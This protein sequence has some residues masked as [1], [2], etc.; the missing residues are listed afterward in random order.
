MTD[1][2]V[3]PSDK[4]PQVSIQL[5]DHSGSPEVPGLVETPKRRSAGVAIGVLAVLAGLLLWSANRTVDETAE[6]ERI[7]EV[8]PAIDSEAAAD[9]VRDP[10]EIDGPWEEFSDDQVERVPM[11][12]FIVSPVRGDDGW[13]ALRQVPG[14]S[15]LV[16][17]EDGLTWSAVESEFASTNL[18]GLD[19]VGE[20]WRTMVN[21]AALNEQRFS[22][23]TQESADTM[24]WE[25][26]PGA[27]LHTAAGNRPT[28]VDLQFGNSVVVGDQPLRLEEPVEEFASLLSTL[29]SPELAERACE[30]ELDRESGPSAFLILDCDGEVIGRVS[31]DDRQQMNTLSTVAFLLQFEAV[32]VVQLDGQAVERVVLP[33]G[34]QVASI[35][36]TVDGFVAVVIDTIGGVNGEELL[37]ESPPGKLIRW[38][39]AEGIVD[40]TGGLD[41][42]IELVDWFENGLGV[43]ADG[44]A[45]FASPSRVFRSSPPYVDWVPVL[46]APIDIDERPGTIAIGPDG[47][48]VVFQDELDQVWFGRTGGRWVRAPQLDDSRLVGV[49]LSSPTHIVGMFETEGFNFGL[50][51]VPIPAPARI[52][53]HNLQTIAPLGDDWLATTR[54]ASG[55][56]R[57]TND[58]RTWTVDAEAAGD[59]IEIYSLGESNGETIALVT[60]D[61]LSP[62]KVDGDI[63]EYDYLDTWGYGDDGWEPLADRSPIIVASGQV[64]HTLVG[65]ISLAVVEDRWQAPVP[66]VI[67]VLEQFV[68]ADVAAKTCALNRTVLADG[69]ADYELL[70]CAGAPVGLIAAADVEVASK[71]DDLLAFTQEVL[72]TRT[73]VYVSIPGRDLQIVELAPSQLIL[74]ITLTDAGF[75]AFILDSSQVL[76]NVDI[77][78]SQSFAALLIGW[79]AGDGPVTPF[80]TPIQTPVRASAWS[81]NEVHANADGSLTVISP[82]GLH[83]GEPPFESW[84]L[85]SAGPIDPPLP[86]RIASSALYGDGFYMPDPRSEDFLFASTEGITW[87]AFQHEGANLR[88]MLIATDEFF[89]FDTVDRTIVR[90]DRDY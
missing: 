89:T 52:D 47:S 3:P 6:E 68:A 69:G 46:D 79:E 82:I 63:V 16:Y 57:S 32:V 1:P 77:L 64:T 55:V 74:D 43:S 60:P 75:V 35:A 59:G 80:A 20:S 5:D 50:V 71:D 7:E 45:Y 30:L 73:V 29:V 42:S 33:P 12:D 15:R 88:R 41:P 14:G 53:P 40:V 67:E 54:G 87:T 22:L 19:R 44:D 18:F 31:V 9:A 39:A 37:L 13:L 56:L 58:G 25:T 17:S 38:T 66:E 21:S 65:D 26:L 4:L 62:L 36:T 23:L 51:R 81:L 90:I 34:E 84:T 8:A 27:E 76:G 86:G 85:L 2:L 48:G 11:G 10:N 83:R 49:L 78:Y 72:R 70:D 61:D 24:N 28:N